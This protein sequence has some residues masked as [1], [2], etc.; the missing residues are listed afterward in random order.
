MYICIHI[1]IYICMH[2]YM[3]MY[4]KQYIFLSTCLFMVL[5]LAHVNMNA[6][7][8]IYTDFNLSGGCFPILQAF[9]I[10]FT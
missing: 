4:R 7:L 2:M 5:H 8:Y 3:C 10:L 9:L 1:Y 6:N